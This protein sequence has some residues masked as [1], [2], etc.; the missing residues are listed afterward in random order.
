MIG[1]KPRPVAF[2]SGARY[3]A[4]GFRNRKGVSNDAQQSQSF[5]KLPADRRGAG[6]VSGHLHK[7]GASH[8]LSN[9]GIWTKGDP[10][11]ATRSLGKK[12]VE[13][14]VD[15]VVAFIEAWKKHK[16]V[17]LSK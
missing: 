9:N 4:A 15:Q 3:D 16:K 7:R 17:G 5:E 14:R 6:R 10:K 8:Q 12:I 2:Y 1:E 13:S 11:T